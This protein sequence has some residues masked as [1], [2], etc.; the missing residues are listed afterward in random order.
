MALPT[1]METFREEVTRQ[2][3]LPSPWLQ[4]LEPKFVEAYKA[5]R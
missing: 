4:R 1:L 3:G 5:I 2:A